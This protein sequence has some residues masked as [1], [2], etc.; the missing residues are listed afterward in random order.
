MRQRPLEGVYGLPLVYPVPVFVRNTF[1]EVPLRPPSWE[2]LFEDRKVQS[3]PSSFLE[4]WLSTEQAPIERQ[5]TGAQ[6][7]EPLPEVEQPSHGSAEHKD[8]S[9]KPCAFFNTKGCESGA[10]CR[11]C[12]LC[13]PGEKKRRRKEKLQLRMGFRHV[14]RFVEDA[15]TRGWDLFSNRGSP[16]RP[17]TSA[18]SGSESPAERLP[19]WRRQKP[20][21][22]NSL[23]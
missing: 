3:C 21:E 6:D 8:G 13:D 22:Q 14:R 11:F 7:D 15:G 9:C 23:S 2:D 12:H 4:G 19:P 18:G 16:M 10:G 17:Q 1:V 20:P 5:L